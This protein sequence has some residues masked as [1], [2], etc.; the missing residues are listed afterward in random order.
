[1]LVHLTPAR[2]GVHRRNRALE[3]SKLPPHGCA[4]T[5]AYTCACTQHAQRAH[6]EP[7]LDHE[8]VVGYQ[9]GAPGKLYH[10]HAVHIHHLSPSP[11]CSGKS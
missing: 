4:Y 9:A 1:M 6:T 8:A 3:T 7:H 5:C 2:R 11:Q 10:A